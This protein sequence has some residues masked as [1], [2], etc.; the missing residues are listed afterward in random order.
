M[1]ESGLLLCSVANTTLLRTEWDP[2]YWSRTLESQVPAHCIPFKGMFFPFPE[3]ASS[4][5]REVVLKLEELEQV[6]SIGLHVSHGGPAFSQSPKPLLIQCL[7]KHQKWLYLCFQMPFWIQYLSV[8]Y[9]R[10]VP[11]ISGCGPQPS[12]ELLYKTNVSEPAL[13]QSGVRVKTVT[14]NRPEFLAVLIYLFSPTFVWRK[15]GGI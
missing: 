4:L 12:V 2:S 14:E 8:L 11:S 3:L 13:H 9:N 1:C 7:S 10:E 6:L 15:Q 5:E